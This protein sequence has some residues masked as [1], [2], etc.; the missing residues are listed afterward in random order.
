M[1]TE[2][3][4]LKRTIDEFVLEKLTPA[5][6]PRVAVKALKDGYDS[7]SLPQPIFRQSRCNSSR[8]AFW[9][10]TPVSMKD[11][12]TT[13]SLGRTIMCRL[14]I[15]VL[16][17]MSLSMAQAAHT[18]SMRHLQTELR[19]ASAAAQRAADHAA[20]VEIG[21][22]QLA[23]NDVEG[24]RSTV[25]YLLAQGRPMTASTSEHATSRPWPRLHASTYFILL[26]TA[27]VLFFVN[28]PG[29]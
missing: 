24:A 19:S 26:L 10:R 15:I 23:A 2:G 16:T 17:C 5:E 14:N 7:T 28:V 3:L 29:D 20:L 27:T 11:S 6:L 9:L 21:V 8:L 18:D 25:D 22:A 1:A 12:D 4:E 13:I